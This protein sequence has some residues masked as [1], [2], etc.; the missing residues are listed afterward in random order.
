MLNRVFPMPSLM[1]F[2]RVLRELQEQ[3]KGVRGLQR[4]VR[5]LASHNEVLQHKIASDSVRTAQAAR[6][7]RRKEQRHAALVADMQAE[8]AS[9]DSEVC[10][11]QMVTSAAQSLLCFCVLAACG[12]VVCVLCVIHEGF[13]NRAVL[14]LQK[15]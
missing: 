9:R 2:Q 8:V 14:V 7:A 15:L 11:R 5:L 4:Q 3:V 10:S 1:R 12:I 13:T 6:E